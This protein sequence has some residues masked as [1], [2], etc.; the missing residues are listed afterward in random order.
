MTAP[1]A[2]EIVDDR[3]ALAAAVADRVA[4]AL[5]AA[6]RA[7]R[8][9]TVA[10]SG[11]STPAPML[12]RL[13]GADLAWERVQVFQVDERVAPDGSDDRNATTLRRELLAHVPAVA[14]LMPVTDP[15]LDGAVGR[16][17]E[18]LRRVCNG[19][20]DVVHLGLGPDGHTASLVPGDPVLGVRDADVALSG[21]YQGLRRM[22]LT[23]PALD[24][25]RT[26]VWEVAGA[27]KVD[28][29]AALLAGGD[30]PAAHVARERATLVVDR[31]A[32]G[33][34]R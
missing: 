16:Y 13:A 29:V 20:L 28:A 1:L 18:T 4:A 14:H 9:A 2:V 27:D 21:P 5:R 33:P 30:I 22:T 6:L 34:E 7:G 12:R 31:A 10:F 19:V 32:A 17:A 25:A 8:A 24:R 23:Y 11:G 3:D 26:L 15:D